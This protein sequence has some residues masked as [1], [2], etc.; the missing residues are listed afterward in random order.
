MFCRYSRSRSPPR[1]T[2]HYVASDT[3]V[4]YRSDWRGP[5]LGDKSNSVVFDNGKIH[6]VADGWRC[7]IP[8]REGL[9]RA[10]DCAE[11]TLASDYRPDPA[12]DALI[13]RIID[14]QRR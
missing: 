6:A 2:S 1:R 11:K 7:E 13:D 14:D 8:L 12:V 3:L 9:R 5:L 10:L 4:S